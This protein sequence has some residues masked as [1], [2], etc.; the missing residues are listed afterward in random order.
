MSVAYRFY[1]SMRLDESYEFVALIRIPGTNLGC[2]VN[3]FH[4]D[5]IPTIVRFRVFLFFSR[6]RAARMCKFTPDRTFRSD[7]NC[8]L[9]GVKR[10]RTFSGNHKATRAA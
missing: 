5:S 1:L 8:R 2:R 7:C 9:S 3:D 4:R 6:F 10:T